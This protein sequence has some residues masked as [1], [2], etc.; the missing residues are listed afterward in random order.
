M[1]E[2]KSKEEILCGL[3]ERGN[4]DNLPFMPEMLKF[5]GQRFRVFKRADKTC[6]TITSRG[7][8]RMRDAVHLEGVRC[9]GSSHGG[10]QAQ[11]LIFWKEAWLKRVEQRSAERENTDPFASRAT[12]DEEA[13]ARNAQITEHLFS[14][15]A[16]ELNRA[17]TELW[18]WDVA[19]YLRDIWS[20][21]VKVRDL[22]R[23][24]IFD[25]FTVLSQIKGYRALMWTYNFLARWMGGVEYPVYQGTLT[26]TPIEQLDLKPGE[27]VRIK[28]RETIIRTLD[29]HNHNR[30]LSFDI[31]MVNFCGGTFRVLTRV[32]KAIDEKTGKMI[33]FSNP[34]IVLEDV[35]C[36]AY[37]KNK[38]CPRNIY[39]FWREV[40]L[41]RVKQ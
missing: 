11:C 17:T 37:Y 2:V 21:N 28:D 38:G 35:T 7:L 18:K 36:Q 15:Q 22:I 10:C 14:C 31:E 30:G 20:K 40:W 13:L 9:N 41:E 19:Q 12:I 39:S 6:D 23:W 3:D 25:L 29:T 34:N 33:H 24:I 26:K 16:T 1:V 32:E 5:C 8:R 4:F 27:L